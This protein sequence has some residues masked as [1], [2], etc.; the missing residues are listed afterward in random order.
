MGNE[1]TPSKCNHWIHYL[2]YGQAELTTFDLAYRT[3]TS[4]IRGLD[5]PADNAPLSNSS[6]A[7]GDRHRVPTWT[8]RDQCLLERPHPVGFS[9]PCYS[10][11]CGA[12]VSH[13][14]AED[15]VADRNEISKYASFVLDYREGQQNHNHSAVVLPGSFLGHSR[16]EP[17]RFPI[18]SSRSVRQL[19]Y[20][21]PGVAVGPRAPDSRT[22][23]AGSCG[24]CSRCRRRGR[25]S[26]PSRKEARCRHTPPGISSGCELAAD[27][28]SVKCLS[29]GCRNMTIRSCPSSQSTEYI[30]Y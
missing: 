10:P 30:P 28:A 6:Q 8:K 25:R 24:R 15:D 4:T 26:A 14:M 22:G 5:E 2:R 23:S 3:L 7:H 27:P 17:S 18:H 20:L 19:S 1:V 12:I 16:F 21:A 29:R 9:Y 11:V 13:R